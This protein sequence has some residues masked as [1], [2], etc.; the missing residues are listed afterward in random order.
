VELF[1]GIL[2]AIT[3]FEKI[4]GWFL[5]PWIV[6]FII[7]FLISIYAAYEETKTMD[8]LKSI[9][10]QFQPSVNGNKN[11]EQVTAEN[12][13]PQTL[14]EAIMILVNNSK[15]QI[16]EAKKTSATL[17]IIKQTLQQQ[18]GT[19]NELKQDIKEIHKT[20]V[21]ETVVRHRPNKNQHE[22]QNKK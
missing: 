11:L 14:M 6:G 18:H 20:V 7:V 8:E 4:K 2:A 10:K 3:P 21:Q 5:A 22:N 1:I 16:N 13:Q 17:N 12:P 15:Q 19:S 9:T